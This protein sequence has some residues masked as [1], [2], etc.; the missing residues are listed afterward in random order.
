MMNY[1]KAHQLKYP[2][3]KIQDDLKWIFQSIMGCEH[4]VLDENKSL[5]RIYSEMKGEY[6]YH[7]EKLNDTYVRFHFEYLTQNE[8]AARL[9]MSQVQ[10]SRAEKKILLKLRGVIGSVA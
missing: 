9:G 7:I 1:F 3:R 4:F 2:N 10:V 8:T 6:N 5:E